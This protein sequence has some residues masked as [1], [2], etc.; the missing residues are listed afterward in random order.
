MPAGLFRHTPPAAQQHTDL[1]AAIEPVI[2]PISKDTGQ[3][4]NKERRDQGSGRRRAPECACV[5][6]TN[7]FSLSRRS[8]RAFACTIWSTFS[9]LHSFFSFFFKN[10]F[11]GKPCHLKLKSLALRWPWEEMTTLEEMMSSAARSPAGVQ[12]LHW[13]RR[14]PTR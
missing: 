10:I 1:G 2:E 14:V 9:L 6:P 3:E 5:V 13:F 7:L 12:I 11:G 4:G 8:R